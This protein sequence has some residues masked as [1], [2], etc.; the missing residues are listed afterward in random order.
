MQ[1]L[2]YILVP[3]VLKVRLGS[4]ALSNVW[5]LGGEKGFEFSIID[6][7]AGDEAGLKMLL[8]R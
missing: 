5:S 3:V 8:L 4:N 7:Q 1:L 2:L 6:F